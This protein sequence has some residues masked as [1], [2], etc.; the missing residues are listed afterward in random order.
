[1]RAR[2]STARRRRLLVAVI[3]A[4]LVT[5]ALA[6]TAPATTTP[7]PVTWAPA[8]S[9]YGIA[10][11]PF[12]VV[13]APAPAGT[14][15]TSLSPG[16][17]YGAGF[18]D[19]CSAVYAMGFTNTVPTDA[20]LPTMAETELVA[21]PLVAGV[22]LTLAFDK[23]PGQRVNYVAIVG[24]PNA[25]VS[26]EPAD[27]AT[28][29]AAGRFTVRA[30]VTDPVQSFSG[31][32]GATF[33]LVVDCSTGAARDY[34]NSLFVTAMHWLDI[35]PPTFTAPSM[36]GLSAHGSN[37]TVATFDGIFAPAFLAAMGIADPSQVQGYI[38]VTAVT[39][40]PN[41]TFAVLGAGDGSLWPADSWK[42]R[43]TNGTWCTHSMM[44]GRLSE[45]GRPAVVGPKGLISAVRPTF[46][47]KRV[48]LA[49]RYELRVY[50]GSKLLIRKTGVTALQWTLR[51]AL[52][53][54]VQLTWKV[55]GR[56]AA[57]TGAWSAVP[58]FRIL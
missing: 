54:G 7:S 47:W 52:P 30:T 43:I 56:N 17:A 24:D 41:A 42:Y 9:T 26:V 57:G 1:M 33:G 29:T 49:T 16:A 36:A 39:G 20:D 14:G 55:R 58:R 46:K 19:A 13:G 44:F 27:P 10:A 21:T 2:S 31:D 28:L 45:P 12:V 5:L 51:S 48:S 8:D 37:G 35:D 15:A 32:V 18:W 25:L 4:L 3:G 34:Q 6:P 53:E 23:T 50:R 40:W 22:P 11:T 38:D